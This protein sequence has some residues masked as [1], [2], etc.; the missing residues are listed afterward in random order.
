MTTNRGFTLRGALSVDR[1]AGQ[2]GDLTNLVLEAGFEGEMDAHLG[3]AKHPVRGRDGGYSRNGTRTK[4]MITEFGPVD[5]D[6]PRDRQA[7]FERRIVATISAA[8][9]V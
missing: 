4:A 1:F 9:V 6:V 8:S 3:Y 7:S 5:I 2:L